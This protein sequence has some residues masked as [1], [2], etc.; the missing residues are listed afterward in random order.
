MNHERPIFKLLADL[1]R[2]KSRTP[3]ESLLKLEKKYSSTLQS[4]DGTKLRG[5]SE[6]K[7][8]HEVA[9]GIFDH[10]KRHN[11]VRV[12]HSLLNAV[13]KEVYKS[14]ISEWFR[15]YGRVDTDGTGKFSLCK[16][17]NFDRPSA[18][19]NPFWT[20]TPIFTKQRPFNF[21]RELEKLVDR[22]TERA[23]K[24]SPSDVVDPILLS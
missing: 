21:A 13:E 11:D 18:V 22:A 15:R 12:I 14:A 2:D 1:K 9:L 19:Q 24:P 8:I 20:L 3:P 7:I 23:D 6:K 5:S 17:K 16:D 4:N 10:V